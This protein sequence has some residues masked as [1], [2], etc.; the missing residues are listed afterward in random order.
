MTILRLIFT[1]F[2]LTS[3]PIISVGQQ[4][5]A[6]SQT[7][8]IQHIVSTI[9]FNE[10]LEESPRDLH[11][12]FSQNPFGLPPS[13]N[14]KMM[15]IFLETFTTDTLSEHIRQ[16]F[17]DSIDKK[18][19]Q[20]VNE[21]LSQ[22]KNQP[23]INAEKEYYTI[24][25]IRKRVVNRYEMEQDPP[26]AERKEL[27]S[28]LA[29]TKS[30]TEMELET[31]VILFRSLVKAFGILNTQRTL[32]DAQIEGFVSN[33]RNQ[34]QSQIEREI[35]QKLM[36]QFYGIDNE[37]IRDYQSFYESEAGRWLSQ[38]TAEALKSAYQ[39]ASDEFLQSIENL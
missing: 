36:V 39:K 1:L 26:S 12:Q 21:W 5:T 30:A 16:T 33:F 10:M 20:S 18:H 7:D 29:Q 2:L 22:E 37:L 3:L 38:T 17:E 14:E 35:T 23:L 27:L 13:Q 34:A 31:Q 9:P 28:N 24:E 11:Q 25:G 6:S 8:A 15:E 19:A 32:S 4:P